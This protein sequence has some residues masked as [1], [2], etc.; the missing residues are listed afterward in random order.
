MSWIVLFREG[1]SIH[2]REDVDFS[3]LVFTNKAAR[4][5]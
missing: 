2:V 5:R 4:R 1:G 3:T